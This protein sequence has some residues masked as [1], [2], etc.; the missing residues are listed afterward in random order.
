MSFE[1]VFHWIDSRKLLADTAPPVMMVERPVFG[2][3]GVLASQPAHGGEAYV[4]QEPLVGP[5]P[6]E[7]SATRSGTHVR[8]PI[9][10]YQSAELAGASLVSLGLE[11]GL[12]AATE[13]R[14]Q[15]SDRLER[16]TLVLGDQ[17]VET[18]RDGRP[19]YRVYAGTAL[20]TRLTSR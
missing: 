14:E 16:V 17:P 15:T 1:I 3:S 6:H 20:W 10:A 13:L 5:G 19:V 9:F 4:P 2:T 7:W 18:V 8:V 12:R 11:L